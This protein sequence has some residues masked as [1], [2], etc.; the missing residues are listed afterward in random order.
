MLLLLLLLLWV[1]GSTI[2]SQALLVLSY[3]SED[4]RSVSCAKQLRVNTRNS[5]RM[6]SWTFTPCSTANTA[7]QEGTGWSGRVGKK[8]APNSTAPPYHLRNEVDRVQIATSKEQVGIQVTV[9]HDKSRGGGPGVTLQC[10]QHA[11]GLER[12]LPRTGSEDIPQMAIPA[13]KN[14]GALSC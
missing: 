13:D 5:C 9:V 4:R 2:T 7:M 11:A 10:L 6:T 8:T 1:V 14:A 3:S 12:L